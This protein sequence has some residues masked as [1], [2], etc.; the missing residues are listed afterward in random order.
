MR[1]RRAG[2]GPASARTVTVT[3]GWAFNLWSVERL[4]RASRP[5]DVRRRALLALCAWTL[6][7]TRGGDVVHGEDYG[8]APSVVLS[9]AEEAFGGGYLVSNLLPAR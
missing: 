8:A 2:G 7:V 9:R 5:C 1:W 6:E 3:P 4:L